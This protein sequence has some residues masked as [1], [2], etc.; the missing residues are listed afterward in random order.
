MV[1]TAEKR[2]HAVPDRLECWIWAN[3]PKLRL[4]IVLAIILVVLAFLLGVGG[5]YLAYRA[6]RQTGVFKT[7]TDLEDDL[8]RASWRREVD[9]RV[10]RPRS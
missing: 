3:G 2:V 9:D 5:F 4:V 10:N 6:L 7:T 1:L 8:K